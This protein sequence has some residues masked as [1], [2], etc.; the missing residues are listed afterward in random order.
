MTNRENGNFAES[1]A[2]ATNDGQRKINIM[3]IVKYFTEC[4]KHFD[5]LYGFIVYSIP[6]LTK[7]IKCVRRFKHHESFLVIFPLSAS[8]WVNM[9]LSI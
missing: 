6:T 5:F 2:N 1:V 3:H 4:L 9:S 8:K 7:K